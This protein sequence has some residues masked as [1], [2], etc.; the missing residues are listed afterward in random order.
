MVKARVGRV[1]LCLRLLECLKSSWAGRAY[2]RPSPPTLETEA[3]TTPLSLHDSALR[4]TRKGATPPER[5]VNQ[6]PETAPNNANGSRRPTCGGAT[7]VRGRRQKLH[8]KRPLADLVRKPVFKNDVRY[9]VAS[10][11]LM[12]RLLQPA[13]ISRMQQALISARWRPVM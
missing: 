9:Y 11:H 3:P 1:R 4:R 6:H 8:W 2:C 10:W 13:F 5:C 12:H 7:K